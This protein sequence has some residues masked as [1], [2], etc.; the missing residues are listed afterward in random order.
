MQMAR[1]RRHPSG[2]ADWRRRAASLVVDVLLPISTPASSLLA[3][4]AIAPSAAAG[5][6]E[7]CSKADSRF[8]T[9]PAALVP[10]SPTPAPV[11]QDT[12]SV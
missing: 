10:P 11:A 8:S 9:R 12:G 3:R 5:G 4:L 6:R 2:W 7:R 1:C